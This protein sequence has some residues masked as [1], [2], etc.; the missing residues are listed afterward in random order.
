MSV[1]SFQVEFRT[2][3]IPSRKHPIPSCPSR[4]GARVMRACFVFETVSSLLYR[5]AIYYPDGRR[6]PDQPQPC[7]RP[8]DVESHL[9]LLQ[10]APR[11]PGGLPE[12]VPARTKGCRASVE[13]ERSLQADGFRTLGRGRPAE[14]TLPDHRRN[15]LGHS[16]QLGSR[17]ERWELHMRGVR[18]S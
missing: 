18:Y 4:Y 13:R 15:H 10:L 6:Q 12:V 5:Q 2:G 7:V 3:Y 11:A 9:E 1:C 17:G 16:F 8:R 14:R